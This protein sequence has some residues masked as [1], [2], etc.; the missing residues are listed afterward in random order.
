MSTADFE[1][2]EAV[3]E[4]MR[5]TVEAETNLPMN[6]DNLIAMRYLERRARR[7]L[8]GTDGPYEEDEA[9][10]QLDQD[11]EGYMMDFMMQMWGGQSVE[12]QSRTSQQ[13]E[14]REARYTS[15]VGGKDVVSTTD[16]KR[17]PK[18]EKRQNKKRRKRDAEKERRR[19]TMHGRETLELGK[20]DVNRYYKK[21][22]TEAERDRCWKQPVTH[23]HQGEL[24]E[25][26]SSSDTSEAGFREQTA[27]PWSRISD[28]SDSTYDEGIFTKQ[29]VCLLE[30][31][32]G[33][34][35]PV[36]TLTLK[37]SGF[38]SF[39]LSLPPHLSLDR[40]CTLFH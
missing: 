38:L 36:D 14:R 37:A 2:P 22:A 18:T 35:H 4:A 27:S 10:D 9:L 19:L 1:V 24:H 11:S 25:L 15:D 34:E 12:P 13:R 17:G 20:T 8:A 7:S 26:R 31:D 16:R 28:Y 30:S 21:H 3:K 6:I 23:P 33:S 29:L 39:F 40:L 32:D 5:K